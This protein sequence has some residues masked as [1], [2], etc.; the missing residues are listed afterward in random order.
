MSKLDGM[1][2]SLAEANKAGR[3][4][5]GSSA[6]R[7][8]SRCIL[9]SALLSGSLAFA[10]QAALPAS[11][12]EAEKEK[13]ANASIQEGL[14]L[15]GRGQYWGAARAFERAYHL[16]PENP[17]LAFNYG[18][19]LQTL[20]QHQRA[21]EPLRKATAARP[22]DAEARLSLGICY[23]GVGRLEEG[24]SELESALLHDAQSLHARFYLAVGLYGLHRGPEADQHLRQMA[25]SHPHSP[26]TFLYVA[27]AYRLTWNYEDAAKMIKKALELD[28][29]SAD[30][31]LERGLIEIGLKH[32]DEAEKALLEALRLNPEIPGA[33]LALGEI[34][35]NDRRAPD[36]A[37]PFFERAVEMNPS[38]TRGYLGLGS[39]YLKKNDLKA[40]EAALRR[41]LE[42][43]PNHERAHYFLGQVLQRQGRREE[44]Q[45]EF[46]EA[47]RVGPQARQEQLRR[48]QV[49]QTSSGSP[50]PADEPH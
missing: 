13:E 43:E 36:A 29:R 27:R 39:A 21:I 2:G 14:R 46:A 25:E 20:G 47:T 8:L 16:Y 30:A 45:R 35:L 33:H 40:A 44:A 38:E 5:P 32:P 28:A 12:S 50:A 26:Q 49:N 7:W 11:L 42:L 4:L 31:H 34:A 48:I 3:R 6:R 22:D 23:L 19:A 37:I 9:I 17:D 18:L 24:I 10:Q 1:C 15:F 41:T